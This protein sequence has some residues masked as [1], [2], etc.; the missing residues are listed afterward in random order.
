MKQTT[1]VRR[2]IGAISGTSMDG[3]DLAL[4]TVDNTG[5]IA[6]PSAATY[7]LPAD[8]RAQL[9]A[10][11]SG[12]RE[13]IDLLGAA[14]HAF[15]A[16][17]G[18]AVLGFLAQQKLEPRH[19]EA[20][21]SHGQTV[22]HRPAG[23]HPFSMQLGD[24]NL[25]V[26]RTGIQT[27]A[28]FRRRDMAAGGEGAPLV[29]PFHQAL[30]SQPARC[31][32]VLNIGGISNVTILRHGQVSG[33]DTGPGNALLDAWAC[34]HIK[35]TFDQDARWA[36]TGK[37]DKALLD[38]LLSDPY[39][40]AAPPKSTGKER[41]NLDWLTPQ[42][43]TELP[44]DVQRTLTTLTAAVN[45]QAVQTWAED[46]DELLLC[47]GGRRNPL[48]VNELTNRLAPLRVTTTD[49]YGLDGDAIEA[50]A[51]AWYAWQRLE[52]MRIPLEPTTGARG[53]RLLGAVYQ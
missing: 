32:V 35:Q 10:L 29:P 16:L 2:F 30:F 25:I 43:T 28:D 1:S 18:E 45:A 36:A 12:Q 21:G 26:E 31:R 5:T 41:Y 24:P 39:L 51:F 53:P 42:L 33:F 7:P 49:T 20:I 34:K 11:A 38:R 17:V 22:R 13:H 52:G 46:A 47:G 9:M 8:L 4:L 15:G 50:G 6:L 23:E 44:E 37:L 40:S 3:L 19:I 27:V 48:L 14:D